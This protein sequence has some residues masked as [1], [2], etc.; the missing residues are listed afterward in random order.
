MIYL[1]SNATTKMA[2]EVLEEMLPFLTEEFGNP[3]SFHTFGSRILE[4][5][6]KGRERLAAL[7]CVS[8]EEV[9][10]TSGGTES[11]NA[12]LESGVSWDP[13]RPGLVTTSVEHPAILETAQYLESQ[14]NPLHVAKVDREGV[15]EIHSLREGITEHTGIVSVMVANNETGVI[16]PVAEAAEAAHEKGA[17]FHT[18]AVQGVGKIPLDIDA[19]GV[20][21]LSLSSHKIHGPKGV[22][23]IYI[24]KGTPFSPL[25][26]GGHQERGIRAGTYNVA[27]IVGLGMAAELARLHLEEEIGPVSELMRILED[28]VLA[29][30]PEAVIAGSGALRL[31]NTAT[32]LFTSVE[33]EA[34]LTLLDLEEIYVSSG[35]ACSTGSKDPSYVLS[36]MGVPQM[37][38]NT[39]IRFSLS[40]YTTR[41]EIERVLEILPPFV[42]KLREISP[43]SK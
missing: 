9:F 16:M 39:A 19:M 35:S 8:P 32:V 4:E 6:E 24:R 22:G 25:I 33:S 42:R 21:M 40:R 36:A 23:A 29:S 11:D 7:L 17:L 1:D 28:G 15:L 31:P 14:G 41:A 3:S 37:Q 10:F 5:V 12:A 43:Y 27:G 26:R 38:A 30:C 34:I 2:P 13:D 20:D 18:D